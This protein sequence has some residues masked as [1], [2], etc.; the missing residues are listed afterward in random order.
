MEDKINR[1]CVFDVE[2][3][4][5]A[6]DRISSIGVTIVQDGAILTSTEYLVN[7]EV[8]FD[9]F[10]T[11]LT[12]I[13]ASM[14]QD[15]PTF[16]SVWAELS[17]LFYHS[18]VVAHNAK[19]DLCVLRKCLAAYEIPAQDLWYACT[20]E[21]SK[22]IL[23]QLPNHKLDT[24]CGVLDIPLNHHSAGSDANACA[25]LMLHLMD[26]NGTSL[27][28]YITGYSMSCPQDN[29][30]A[31]RPTAHPSATT[32]ALHDLKLLVTAITA[33]NV[34]TE[35]EVNFLNQWVQQ[36][37]HL[38]GNYPFDRI[39][40]TLSAALEDGILEQ[41]ELDEML[42]VLKSTLDPVQQC[43]LANTGDVLEISGKNICL[44]G[45]FERCA[46]AQVEEELSSLGAII[47]KNVTRKTVYLVVG[48][49]GSSAWSA[50]NYGN[51]VKKALE[52]Q[53]KGLPIQIIREAEFFGELEGSCVGV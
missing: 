40:A 12:G 20:L 7:P 34:L 28:R 48:G 3:P 47:Q 38:D 21:A 45:D 33:D 19:F 9:A 16:P 26:V 11:Q 27:Q 37:R 52:L 31:W 39:L 23:P 15:K 2:T 32:Q 22:E 50:G 49:R 44:T 13:D 35:G 5:R 6:N 14:V 43:C 18:I 42:S 53:G 25:L 29:A 17:D 36:N 41:H 51:K 46:R 24:V 8:P 1:Y 10:N 4:N 30:A